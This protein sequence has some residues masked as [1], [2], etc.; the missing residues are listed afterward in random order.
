MYTRAEFSDR[1]GVVSVAILVVNV[2]S[3]LG[4]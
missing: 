4:K 3:K 2:F 1:M